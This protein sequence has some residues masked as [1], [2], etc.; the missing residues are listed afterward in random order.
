MPAVSLDSVA[1]DKPFDQLLVY[2]H[3]DYWVK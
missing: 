3:F 1:F 2:G